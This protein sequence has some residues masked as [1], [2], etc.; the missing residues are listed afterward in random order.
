MN[1]QSKIPL[2]AGRTGERAAAAARLAQL[3]ADLGVGEDRLQPRRSQAL[4]RAL[5][6]LEALVLDPARPEHELSAF[7]SVDP[8]RSRPF[9]PALRLDE[10]LVAPAARRSLG[11][12]LKDQANL[13][14]RR[15]RQSLFRKRLEA[16]E[17]S[18][19]LVAEGDS[20]F[21]FPVFL[22]DVVQQLGEDHL[23]WTI[24]AAG[25]QLA[26]MVD[27]NAMRRDEDYRFALADHAGS[28]RAMLL[29]GGG[30]DLVG[31]DPDGTRVLSRIL[32]PYEPGRPAAWFLDTG[33]C[34][35][36]LVGIE[37]NLRRV[38][39]EVAAR[40]PDLP[41]LIHGYDY[42]L[43]CPWGPGDKRQ[44]AWTRRDGFLGRVLS[45]LGFVDAA[46][47][48][49]MIRLLIDELNSVQKKLA[50]GSGRGAFGHVFHVD[51]RGALGHDDW[52][53][54]LHPTDAGYA[55]V[56]DRFRTRLRALGVA[57]RAGAV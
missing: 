4:R 34:H 38:F 15:R 40:H 28:A 56:A 32:R 31:V 26:G 35:R 21:H 39:A 36:R 49:E 7:L 50:G 23:I 42:A 1:E 11:E 10:R 41:V 52:A 29:S 25:E 14:T 6:A 24:G 43:P 17:R 54:E 27:A 33:E 53:D 47:R 13:L 18:P 5:D 2:P 44:P 57:G 12:V 8:E 46:L 51:L 9:A 48:N 20:W 30:N 3:F 37:A 19:V 16:G 55:K 22:R 45:E